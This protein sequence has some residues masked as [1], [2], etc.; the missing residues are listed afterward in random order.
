V[1]NRTEPRLQSFPFAGTCALDTSLRPCSVSYLFTSLRSYFFFS[2][3]FFV[4]SFTDPHLL[5]SLESRRFKKGAG[6]GHF[7][8]SNSLAPNPLRFSAFAAPHP[9]TPVVSIFYKN[10]AGGGTPYA[11]VRNLQS[12]IGHSLCPSLQRRF[13]V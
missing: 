10:S 4:I 2:K 11:P 8:H 12:K 3:S 7:R 6:R 13:G 5:T 1:L 9:L